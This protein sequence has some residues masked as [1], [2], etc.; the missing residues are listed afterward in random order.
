MLIQLLGQLRSPL[1]DLALRLGL[2]PYDLGPRPVTDAGGV[3][4]GS[5]PQLLGPSSGRDAHGGDLGRHRGPRTGPRP[6]ERRGGRGGGRK[7]RYRWA[8][9]PIK[10]KNRE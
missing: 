4:L 9:V 3:L 2:D 10:K 6:E 8:P 7:G 5:G 1:L